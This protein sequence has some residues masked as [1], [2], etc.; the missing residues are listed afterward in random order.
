MTTIFNLKNPLFILFFLS[1]FNAFWA[2]NI[3]LSKDAKVSVITCGLGNESYSLFGHTAI[4]IKDDINFVDAVYNY[5]AF[6]FTRLILSQ[7]LPK[8]IS[9]ILLL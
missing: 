3:Q 6:D 8:E 2:Q 9:N 1:F 5:G 7:N 4:R